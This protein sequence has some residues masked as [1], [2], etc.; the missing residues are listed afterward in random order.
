VITGTP[1][2]PGVTDPPSLRP[3]LAASIAEQP[4]PMVSVPASVAEAVSV[5]NLPHGSVTLVST[6]KPIFAR[7]FP[8]NVEFGAGVV[9]PEPVGSTQYTPVPEPVLITLIVEPLAATI[10][11]GGL[12][13]FDQANLP[14]L[15]GLHAIC[16]SIYICDTF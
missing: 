5:K 4:I 8:S 12:R 1:L 2:G 10:G 6:A 7:I 3:S 13:F 11:G 9:V 15:L 14:S 16:V